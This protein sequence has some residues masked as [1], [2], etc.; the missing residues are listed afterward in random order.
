MDLLTSLNKNLATLIKWIN[1]LLELEMDD[2][3]NEKGFWM[4]DGGLDETLLWFLGV[5]LREKWLVLAEFFRKWWNPFKGG[6]WG[7]K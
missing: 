6:V 1:Y 3:D 7:F 5:F 4:D 2:L